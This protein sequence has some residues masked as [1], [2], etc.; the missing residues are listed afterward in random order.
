MGHTSFHLDPA[1]TEAF[2][3]LHAVSFALDCSFLDVIIEG[4]AL[5]VISLCW[6]KESSFALFG[7]IIE[8]A[9]RLGIRFRLCS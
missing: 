4:D 1:T 2:A 3:T 9:K 7:H 5:S 6:N 8:D